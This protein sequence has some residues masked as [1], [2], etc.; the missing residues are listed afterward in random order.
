MGDPPGGRSKSLAPPAHREP[1]T[2]DAHRE[3]PANGAWPHPKEGASPM[4]A[5]ARFRCVEQGRCRPSGM[6]KGAYYTPG[7]DEHGPGFNRG[8]GAGA[9]GC[10][11]E[12]R[13]EAY[14]RTEGGFPISHDACVCRLLVSPLKWQLVFLNSNSHKWSSTHRPPPPPPSP[15]TRKA[16]PE[17]KTLLQNK[18]HHH[19]VLLHAQ[20]WSPPRSF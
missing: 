4:W 16:S 7:S 2:K 13:V 9:R 14:A 11:F 12:E 18:P 3:S 5:I 6:K 10:G 15:P 1:P 19:H 17:R 8:S 20:G